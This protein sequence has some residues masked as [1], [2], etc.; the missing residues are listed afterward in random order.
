MPK[1]PYP[2]SVTDIP[3]I[4]HYRTIAKRGDERAVNTYFF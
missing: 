2:S 1:D 3:P 4:S